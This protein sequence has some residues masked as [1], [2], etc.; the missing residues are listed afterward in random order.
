MKFGKIV[1]FAV[2]VI[3]AVDLG[4]ATFTGWG[5][6]IQDGDSI[7]IAIKGKKSIPV[8]LGGIDCPELEQDFGKE[9]SDFTKSFVYRKKVAVEIKTYNADGVIVARAS[10]DGKDLS[11]AL[12]EAG[13]AWYYKKY[14]SDR[15]L[16]KAQKK[17]KKAKKGLW[18]LPK[19]TPP[20]TFRETQE[21]AKSKSQE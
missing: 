19:P 3:A 15:M 6:K 12:I 1:F 17:A 8:E 20:W 13:L 7:L 9:A 21:K 10:V 16:S 2:L 14:D 11:L 18:S 5:Y 4:A